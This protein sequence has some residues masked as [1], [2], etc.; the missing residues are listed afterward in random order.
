MRISW[1]LAF[2]QNLCEGL[3]SIEIK[4]I[5]RADFFG[6]AAVFTFHWRRGMSSAALHEWLASAAG[7]R[8]L[9]F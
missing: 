9:A 4:S 5:K 7:E 8:L 3:E 6:Y 2:P 1:A